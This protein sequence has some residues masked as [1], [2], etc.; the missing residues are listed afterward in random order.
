MADD[1]SSH[2][3]HRQPND[4][5]RRIYDLEAFCIKIEQRISSVELKTKKI[6]ETRDY[7]WEVLSDMADLS[8]EPRDNVKR[9]LVAEHRTLQSRARITSFVVA[10]LATAIGGG[11]IDRWLLMIL[12]GTGAHG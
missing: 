11:L 2:L 7:T 1:D 4:F 10:L 3:H 8:S 6:E 12:P 9:K 5:E